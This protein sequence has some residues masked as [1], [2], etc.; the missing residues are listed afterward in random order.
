MITWMQHHKKYLIVTVWIS[1]IAFVAA[2]FIGWGAYDF[3]LTRSSSVAKVGNRAISKQLFSRTY[4]NYFNDYNIRDFNGELTQ[5]QA[6]EMGLENIVL[7]TLINEA[8]ILNFADEL[9]ITALDSD[10][11]ELI[12]TN[13]NFYDNG[14]FSKDIYRSVLRQSGFKPSDYEDILKLGIILNKLYSI[15]TNFPV[16]EIDK[17]ILG[18]A[19]FMEDR[20]SVATVTVDDSEIKIGEDEIKSYWDISKNNFLTEKVYHFESVFVP[21]SRDNLN[22]DDIKAYYEETKYFY[23]DSE[24]RVLDYT[25]AKKDVEKALRIENAKKDALKTYLSFKKGDITADKNITIKESSSEYNTS[26]FGNIINN[27]EVLQPIQKDNGWEVL[28]LISIELPAPKTY[29]EAKPQMLAILK[30]NKKIELLAQKSQARLNA[31]KGSDLGF[32]T[33]DNN[34]ITGLTS[35]QSA[36]FIGNVFGSKEKRGYVIFDDK[37]YLYNITEQKLPNSDKLKQNDLNLDNAMKRIR[38]YEIQQK[39]INMLSQKYKIERYYKG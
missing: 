38:E 11:V 1:V 12:T 33:R 9:G 20:L 34:N 24:N 4:A 35:Q 18:S 13:E 39:L 5:E 15:I 8:L 7:D 28:K 30:A 16:S 22:E 37:A 6:K 32:I 3:N 25:A 29:E 21:L 19:L 36:Q 31:F 17:E 26:L 10:V 23:Q 27:G 14:T 2:G